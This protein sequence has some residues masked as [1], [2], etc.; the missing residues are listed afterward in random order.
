MQLRIVKETFADG[1][2]QYRVEYRHKTLIFPLKW[3]K[4]L[5]EIGYIKP[6]VP[7]SGSELPE[8]V[9]SDYSEAVNMCIIISSKRK[10]HPAIKDSFIKERK[11][12]RTF[13]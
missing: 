1:S 6:V 10:N 3:K 8:A 2:N 11:V 13:K 12:I 9:F 4:C 5:D 7:G